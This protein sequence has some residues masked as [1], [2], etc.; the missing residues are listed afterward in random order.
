MRPSLQ[1]FCSKLRLNSRTKVDHQVRLSEARTL[2]WNP[3]E[4]PADPKLVV[5][6]YLPVLKA[7]WYASRNAKCWPRKITGV[8]EVAVC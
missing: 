6:L 8:G 5:P 1:H 2:N 4:M 7:H 3:S